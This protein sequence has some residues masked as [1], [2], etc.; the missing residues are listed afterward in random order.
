MLTGEWK[1]SSRS[2]NEGGNCVEAR[3]KKSSRSGNTG[4]NC[5]EVRGRAGVV[6]VRDTK[7]GE[8]SPILDASPADWRGFLTAVAKLEATSRPAAPPRC[9]PDCVQSNARCRQAPGV[10]T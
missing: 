8:T 6:Q 9:N 4:G 5:V 7:L 2:G 10:R 3:W 1:K